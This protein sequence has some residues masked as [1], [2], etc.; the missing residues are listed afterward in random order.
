MFDDIQEDSDESMY[1]RETLVETL[2]KISSSN[3]EKIHKRTC[4]FEKYTE[5]CLNQTFC[6]LN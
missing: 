1:E 5:K 3:N 6:Q 4:D 2:N